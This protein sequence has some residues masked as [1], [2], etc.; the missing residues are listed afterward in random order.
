MLLHKG[1]RCQGSKAPDI[2][3]TMSLIRVKADGQV[4][5]HMTRVRRHPGRP[6]DG[7]HRVGGGPAHLRAADAGA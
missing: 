4:V 7:G 2:V 3:H 6:A 5:E 1:T